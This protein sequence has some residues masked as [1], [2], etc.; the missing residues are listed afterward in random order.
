MVDNY[1]TGADSDELDII[2]I[3]HKGFSNAYDLH[4]AIRN[5]KTCSVCGGDPKRPIREA[6]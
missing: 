5:N 2:V 1:Y 3:C 6:V 4:I